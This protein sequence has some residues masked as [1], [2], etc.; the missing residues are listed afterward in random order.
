MNLPLPVT[1][2]TMIALPGAE[3]KS[4]SGVTSDE[5]VTEKGD[6]GKGDGVVS[7]LS[8]NMLV[9]SGGEGYIDFRIGNA[10][11]ISELSAELSA[12]P[13]SNDESFLSSFMI[14]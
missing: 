6:Q 3:M 14:L 2:V 9:I 13:R 12:V 7:H 4:L 10:N 8:K 1:T 5:S 11:N